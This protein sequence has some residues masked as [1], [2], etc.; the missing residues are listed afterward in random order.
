M[1]LID[2]WSKEGGTPKVRE[3]IEIK[4]DA[5]V[6]GN[7]SSNPGEMAEI[8]RHGRDTRYATGS[9]ERR[10][11]FRRRA[12]VWVQLFRVSQHSVNEPGSPP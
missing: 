6:I 5:S 4:K 3:S 2:K 12:D 9:L 1:C 11:Q 10:G 7:G 8:R